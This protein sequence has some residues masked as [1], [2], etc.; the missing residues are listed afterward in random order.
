MHRPHGPFDRRRAT[1]FRAD[2]SCVDGGL[3]RGLLPSRPANVS[4][5]LWVDSDTSAKSC[6]QRRNPTIISPR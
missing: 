5:R 3:L 2:R 1:A 4:S 6:R